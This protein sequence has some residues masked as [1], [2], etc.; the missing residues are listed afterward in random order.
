MK[1][2]IYRAVAVKDI[3]LEQLAQRLPS[4]R[5]VMGIDVAKKAMYSVL[6]APSEEI[7]AV[8]RW[9]H[10]RESRQI[11]A[12]LAALP[13]AVKEAVMEPSGTYGD[14]LRHCLEQS[15][16]PVYQVSPKQV[17]DSR[18]IYDGVPSSHDA[19][20]SAIIA[21]LHLL[22][23]SSR[24][25]ESPECERELSALVLRLALHESAFSSGLNR[26][27]AQL[28][29]YWPEVLELLDLD[30]ATLLELLA[31]FGSPQQVAARREQAEPLMRRVGGPML[32]EE[33]I[34]QVLASAVQTLGV[35]MVAAERA[36]LLDLASE[37]RR[38]QKLVRAAKRRVEAQSLKDPATARV[39]EVAGRVTAAVLTAKLGSLASYS[40]VGSLLK[41][42]G[43]NL[44]ERSSGRRQG[45]L[46]IT[47]RG[48]SQPRQYLYLAVLRWIQ[49]DPW[50]QRWYQHK[51][52]RDGGKKK[53]RAL[54]ALMRKLLSG[55]W[56]VAR[57]E[58]FDST[59]LFD[60]RRLEPVSG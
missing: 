56:W 47:K 35:P 9:D 21:W 13:V 39:G 31:R 36:T 33:K 46:A 45:E 37:L 48:P 32:S 12:W 42:A 6:M 58:P 17:K 54:V 10:L 43:L 20:A 60:T 38:R 29:R 44:K 23:R 57:G 51:V 14:A 7:L 28:A 52:Q 18:E 40:D 34:E 25:E 30:A 49:E 26:L 11:V 5:I 15:G 27:E 8:L 53:G 59:K 41:G 24:W 22:G 55:L 50:A 3:D 16:V 19:K 2:R 1:K 4:D